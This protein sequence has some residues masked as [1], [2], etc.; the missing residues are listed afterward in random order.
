MYKSLHST[1]FGWYDRLDIAYSC[2]QNP[3]LA[4]DAVHSAGKWLMHCQQAERASFFCHFLQMERAVRAERA[5]F[6]PFSGSQVDEFALL[7]YAVS[8]FVTRSL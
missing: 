8:V 3:Y 6:L 5:R 4:T 1:E 2:W 7:K